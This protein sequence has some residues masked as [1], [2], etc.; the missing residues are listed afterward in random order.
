M[1]IE[2]RVLLEDECNED[3]ASDLF[4]QLVS[5]LSRED[6]EKVDLNEG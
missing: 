2:L 3:E 1:Q 5:N 4:K 6:V